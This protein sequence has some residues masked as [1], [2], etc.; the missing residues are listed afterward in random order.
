M[1][2]IANIVMIQTN[3]LFGVDTIDIP[4]SSGFW[5]IALPQPFN[6]VSP[7]NPIP[8]SGQIWPR[9]TEQG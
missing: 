9:G 1:A 2:N 3:S 8:V 5:R 7:T 6:V 4:N